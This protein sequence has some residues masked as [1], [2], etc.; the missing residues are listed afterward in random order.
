MKLRKL[1]VAV[2]CLVLLGTMGG[3]SVQAATAETS[4]V[5]EVTTNSEQIE[6]RADIIEICYRLTPEG[7]LQYRRWNSTRGYWV[8]PEWINA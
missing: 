6:P 8:D 4:I 7:K 1:L 2:M 5:S 3:L